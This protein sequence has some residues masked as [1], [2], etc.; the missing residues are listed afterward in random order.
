M[1][2]GTGTPLPGAAPRSLERGDHGRNSER[3]RAKSRSHIVV[4]P[5]IGVAKAT[6]YAKY[7]VTVTCRY[8]LS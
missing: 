7:A 1:G 2:T 3:S 8:R 5:A 6:D 4:L